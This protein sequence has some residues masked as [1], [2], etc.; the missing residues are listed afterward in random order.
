MKIARDF[1]IYL[2]DKY[3]KVAIKFDEYVK[4]NFAS[5]IAK[6]DSTNS[7]KIKLQVLYSYIDAADE[8]L[9]DMLA[10]G[11]TVKMKDLEL[12]LSL[13]DVNNPNANKFSKT[14]QYAQV[15]VDYGKPFSSL[16][17][18]FTVKMKPWLAAKFIEYT[19][20]PDAIFY[21]NKKSQR[22]KANINT[23]II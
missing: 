12:T 20:H 21:R 3:P 1:Y 9:I 7:A 8:M 15:Y 19:K 14:G 4:K 10:T 5:D 22:K 13:N 18:T 16:M 6:Q 17:Q 23:R 11:K 2:K